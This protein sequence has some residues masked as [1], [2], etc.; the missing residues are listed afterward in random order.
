VQATPDIEFTVCDK[1]TRRAGGT[2]IERRG[3]TP[4]YAS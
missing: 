3:T 1:L 2:S 4:G